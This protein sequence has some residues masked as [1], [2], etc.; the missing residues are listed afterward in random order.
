MK[1]PEFGNRSSSASASALTRK[2]DPVAVHTVGCKTPIVN[3]RSAVGVSKA[4]PSCDSNSQVAWPW[5]DKEIELSRNAATRCGGLAEFF[6]VFG[7]R[8]KVIW[9]YPGRITSAHDFLTMYV[10]RRGQTGSPSMNGKLGFLTVCSI[11]L[12]VIYGIWNGKGTLI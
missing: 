12:K 3:D 5:I 8:Q 4:Y 7:G 2:P 9:V 10:E 1:S 6:G 11:L